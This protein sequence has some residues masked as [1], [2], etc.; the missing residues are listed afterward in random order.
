LDF[1]I[2]RQFSITEKMKLQWQ[3]DFFNLFNHTN[4]NGFDSQL[5][6]FG[7]PL[8]PNARFGVAIQD[9]GPRSI[10]LSLRLRF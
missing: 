9:A 10:Q 8:E 1:D 3:V 4:F 6:S 7:P 5:G 2:R